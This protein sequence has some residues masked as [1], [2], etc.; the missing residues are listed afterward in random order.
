MTPATS[1]PERSFLVRVALAAA[2]F[3]GAYVLAWIVMLLMPFG[4][5]GA[6][7]GLVPPLVACWIAWYVWSN[8]QSLSGSVSAMAGVGAVIVG[9]IG[10][11][12]GFFGPMLLAPDANQGPMLGI[13]ITGPLG[14]I[15]GAIGG[16]LYARRQARRA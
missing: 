14:A 15:V 8:P 1:R 10:F 6:I 11:A 12:I 2:A 9:G 7:R 5:L 4:G 13:F 3:L 16:A